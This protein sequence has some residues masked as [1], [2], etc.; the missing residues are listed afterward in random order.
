M[1]LRK[2]D[3]EIPQLNTSALPDLIFTVLFF[4][5][6]VT[7]MRQTDVK[8]SV[9][10]PS[11]QEL[12]KADKKY[13]T[14]SIYIGKDKAGAVRTQFGNKIIPYERI[15]SQVETERSKVPGDEQDSYTVSIK[16]DRNV[17]LAVIARVKDELRK[18]GVQHINYSATDATPSSQR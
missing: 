2:R 8:V 12:Q 10:P 9:T 6:I 4:F 17:P 5:M 15:A 7:H 18:A 14:S 1:R 13:L 16:A 3:R 11:G